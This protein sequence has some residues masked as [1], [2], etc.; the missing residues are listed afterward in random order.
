[1]KLRVTLAIFILLGVSIVPAPLWAADDLG[2]ALSDFQLVAANDYLELLLHPASTEIAVFD[3]RTGVIWYSNP[4]E[5]EN[6]ERISRG[7]ARK[8]LS[9]QLQIVYFTP[10]QS[11]RELDNFTHGVEYGQFDITYLDDGLRID[12]VLGKEWNDKDFLPVMIRV[13]EFD[14]LLE[15]LASDQER[16]LVLNNYQRVSLRKVRESDPQI[17]LADVDIRSLLGDYA[18]GIDGEE[19]SPVQLR[20]LHAAVI[21]SVISNRKDIDRRSQLQKIHLEALMHTLQETDVMLLQRRV[22]RWDLD[23]M[24]DAIRSSGYSPEQIHEEH[25]ATSLDPPKPNVEVFH[26]PIIYSIKGETFLVEVPSGEIEFP[27]DVLDHDGNRVTYPL[28]SVSVLPFFGAADDTEEG[29]IFVPDGSGALINLNNNKTYTPAYNRRVYGT[30]Y[31]LG[32]TADDDTREQIYLPVYGMKRADKAFVAIIDEGASLA[33]IRADVAGRSTSFNTVA[34]DFAVMPMG[35]ISLYG[36]HWRL[37]N[38]FQERPYEGNFRI[39]FGFLYDGNADYV[40]MARYYQSYLVSKYGL[41]K[42]EGQTDI[43]LFLEFIGGVHMK[44]P[45]LGLPLRIVEPLTTF[46]QARDMVLDFL[47]AGISSIELRY[48]GWL[49]GG[50][51]HNFPYKARV[52]K[53]VGTERDF[54]DLSNLLSELDIPLYPDV[55]MLNAYGHKFKTRRDAARL[56]DRQIGRVY[57]REITEYEYQR[58]ETGYRYL[59]SPNRLESLTQGFMDSYDRFGLSNI[60]FKYMGTQVNSNFGSNLVDREHAV[61]IIIDQLDAINQRGYNIMVEGGN[62]LVLPYVSS[63]VNAPTS[64]SDFIILDH[65]VPFY[66]IA[67]RGYANIAGAPMNLSPDSRASMLRAIE[68]G[69]SPYFQ[70]VANDPSVL[71]ESDFNHL[72]AVY[73]ENWKDTVLEFYSQINEALKGVQGQSIIEHQRLTHNVYKT[74]Y[75]NHKTIIVNYNS[76]PI[77]VQGFLVEGK[78]FR[79]IGEG[80]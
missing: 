50:L 43:P 69:T 19:L 77:I 54:T 30:D 67:T 26:I 48:S 29:Y 23:D 46:E 4:P 21:D 52:E 65:T 76:E 42:I 64:S 35:R 66:Q 68:T 41:K 2:N 5:R 47:D 51:E 63:I 6:K 59:V 78:G 33:R 14:A 74:V 3:K 31:S 20:E 11:R 38:V 18:F 45:V 58:G 56:L 27:I 40:G 37:R 60:S 80:Y 70:L 53:Q 10:D 1:M 13:N 73:Y 71:K 8:R 57:P 9:S 44:R 28:Y 62:A 32:R 39:Q 25:L 15:G 17:D 55:T 22:S 36:E 12:Y 34:G 72:V 24:I 75:E 7:D 49:K 16:E 79:V 61:A